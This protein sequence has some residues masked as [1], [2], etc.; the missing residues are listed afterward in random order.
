MIRCLP[1]SQKKRI[2]LTKRMKICQLNIPD[3]SKILLGTP[4]RLN[5]YEFLLMDTDL[6]NSP[7]IISNNDRIFYDKKLMTPADIKE[8]PKYLSNLS[9][10][11][12][13]IE[14]CIESVGFIDSLSDEYHLGRVISNRESSM[15]F[16]DLNTSRYM[17]GLNPGY[18]KIK[19]KD[20]CIDDNINNEFVISLNG[21]NRILS[22]FKN[23]DYTDIVC[24]DVLG[25]II[26]RN[27]NH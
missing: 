17:I 27:L 13:M 20:N 7:I 23:F 8:V 16:R 15:L 25:Y 2:E 10:H 21:R 3:L 9:K 14:T 22:K 1:I 24:M 4:Y 12:I 11:D 6:F 18:I 19:L 5:K 26:G